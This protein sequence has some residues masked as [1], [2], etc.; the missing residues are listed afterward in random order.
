MKIAI[1]NALIFDGMTLQEPR[2][3]VMEDG[4][5]IDSQEADT[6]IDGSGC[7]LLPGLIESHAHLYAE[8]PKFLKMAVNGGITTMMDMGIRN[9]EAVEQL[10]LRNL[11]GMPQVFSSCGLIFAPGS[12]MNQRMGY[13]SDMVLKNLEDVSTLVDH[14]VGLGAD[15]IKMIFEDPERNDGVLFPADISK[16]VVDRAHMHGKLVCAHCVSNRSYQLA[17]NAGV[18]VI[19]HIPYMDHLPNELVQVI[20]SGNS[21]VVPTMIMGKNLLQRIATQKPLAVKLLRFIN[22]L[23]RDKNAFDFTLR[24][25]LEGLKLLYQSGANILIGTD[26]TLEDE[27][28]VASVPYGEGLH[29]EMEIFAQADIPNAYI[30]SGATSRAASVWK[31]NDRGIIAPGMRADLLLVRG[32]PVQNISDIRNI[33]RVW[34]KGQEITQ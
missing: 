3:I 19:A 6:V 31:L 12:V 29:Q 2:R 20:A 24:N 11:P 21:S 4:I 17:L 27:L 10:G 13:P 9:P 33:Q 32:N 34:A 25:A 23:K 18:D 16:A 8:K 30:L 26:S 14:Q 1:D 22:K 7:T 28:T 15:Y 5:I